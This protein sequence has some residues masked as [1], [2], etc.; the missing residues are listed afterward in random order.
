MKKYSPYLILFL[1]PIFSYA[2][3]SQASGVV[4]TA[5]SATVASSLDQLRGS[6]IHGA[7]DAPLAPI[8]LQRWESD[9]GAVQR[10]ELLGSEKIAP[11]QRRHHD[12]HPTHTTDEDRCRHPRGK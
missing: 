1:L 6:S 9:G 8:V 7:V 3:S 10:D 2:C 5:G 12:R 11:T 4:T